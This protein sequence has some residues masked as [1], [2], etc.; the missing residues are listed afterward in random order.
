MCG[1]TGFWQPAGIDACSSRTLALRMASRIAHRGPDD[2]DA[3]VDADAGLALSH[4]RLAIVDL[5]PAGHQPMKSPSGRFV[6]AFN[7]E[8]YNHLDLRAELQRAVGHQLPWRGHSDTETLLAAIDTWGLA[9]TLRRTVGMFALALWD[10]EAC[11]LQL[12]RDRVG[13]KPLYY[14]WHGRG[15]ARALL[16]G[17]EL[18]AMR[19][20]PAF[21]A[22]GEGEVDR[23]ALLLFMRHGYVPAPYSIH[24]GVR[25]LPP[26]TI[27]TFDIGAHVPTIESYWSAVEA[28]LR[29]HGAPLDIG[30]DEA[31]DRLQALLGD[32]IGRQMVAD[33]PLGAFLSGG[34]D[35][36][37]I[38]ALMQ[39]QSSTP[40][41][42]FSIGFHEEGY[43]EAQHAKAVAR[44]LGTQHT[45]LYVTPIEAMGVVPQLP[46]M[47]DEPFADS[48]QIPTHLV[49]ALARRHVTVALSGDAGDELFGGYSR[50]VITHRVW[51]RIA[52]VPMPLRRLAAAAL[53]SISETG[54]NRLVT[55]TRRVLPVARRFN[56]LGD[57]VHKGAQAMLGRDADALYLRTVSQ[58]SDPAPLV[59]G[60]TEPLTVLTGAP[61]PLTALPDVPR[62][63]AYDLLTYLPDDI[64]VKIDR[65]AMA[66]SLETRVPMLDH[67][68]IEFAWQLPMAHKLRDGIGKWA[69]R[70]VLYRHVPRSLVER[71]KMGFGV[72]IDSWLRGPLRDWAEALLAPALLRDHGLADVPIRAAWKAHLEGSADAQYPLWNVLMY[73][74][75]QAHQAAPRQ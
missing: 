68:V 10:R 53:T 21:G 55:A 70:Q 45:E 25:K 71:P 61:T 73:Q 18:K 6:I 2:A 12:A 15:A 23:E 20:H 1:L 22:D 13:E 8:I 60:A 27:G 35:S 19:A 48:S 69:L 5:S 46:E 16:F 58:W 41:R 56:R 57:K 26:G 37:T 38:V 54:W 67:R 3:W 28:M 7:G 75:W 47:Y 43:D 62:M 65:A 4:R 72:P 51:S 33:V 59:P 17:S 36:S 32:A 39:A 49:A 52:A 34:I 11:C 42:T 40:V 50:Y 9:A 31:V 63:M 44:H 30:P 66:V 24:R 74:A 29:G 14:G 64:L